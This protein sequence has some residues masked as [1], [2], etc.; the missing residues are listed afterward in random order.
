MFVHDTHDPE[1]AVITKQSSYYPRCLLLK[2]LFGLVSKHLLHLFTG[3]LDPIDM[4]AMLSVTPTFTRTPDAEV[5][6][7]DDVYQPVSTI[8]RKLPDI[9]GANVGLVWNF[10]HVNLRSRVGNSSPPQIPSS[11]L[12][13][14]YCQ[15]GIRTGQTWQMSFARSISSFR[16]LLVGNHKFGSG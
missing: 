14:P 10:D 3:H 16:D 6:F 8:R 9:A 12:I 7:V 1:V 15:H 2:V 5:S 13:V 4:T 11:W